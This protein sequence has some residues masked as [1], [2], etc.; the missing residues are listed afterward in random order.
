MKA[1]RLLADIG[2]TNAR[3]AWQR[4]GRK[5]T[6]VRVL[7]VAEHP[8]LETAID[9]YCSI[10]DMPSRVSHVA[11]AVAGPVTGDRV[12]LTNSP[13][14]F[15]TAEVRQRFGFE[16]LEVI[17]DFAALALA[18][19]RLRP[20]ERIKLGRGRAVPNAPIGV[21]GPG[22]GLG[23]AGLL[24]TDRGPRTLP[25]EGGKVAL[26]A[27][28]DREAHVIEIL[29]RAT[30]YVSAEYVLSGPGLVRLYEALAVA[31]G[32]TARA[33]SAATITRAA[34][35]GRS[36]LAVAT[37]DMFAAMLGTVAGDLAMTI[38]SL[39]GVYLG[40]GIVPRLGEALRRSPFRRRFEQR[41][42]FSHYLM[43]IPTYAI[44][45]RMPAFRGL[46]AALDAIEENTG[47]TG[48][49][50]GGRR[51]TGP[52]TIELSKRGDSR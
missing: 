26:P 23:M 50:R 39:G 44:T 37:V 52:T 49:D 38:G 10:T 4:P 17:N 31:A 24:F 41:G 7:P 5:P 46:A 30:D 29:R 40:G 8:T 42:T 32:R 43:S 14:T 1:V 6:G 18:I 21:L 19:P 11:L 47:R 48:A 45:A 3:F 20:D 16:H 2:G 25:S 28:D 33:T 15:S 13:W 35:N 22:T 27:A 9:H 51:P 34:L 12:Q 36:Q